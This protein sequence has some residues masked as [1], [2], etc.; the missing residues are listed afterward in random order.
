M[1]L[2]NVL[3]NLSFFGF[4]ILFRF[5]LLIYVAC[6][7]LFEL[8]RM[9]LGMNLLEFDLIWIAYSVILNEILDVV[10]LE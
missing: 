3:I 4:G 8:R 2:W 1:K 6:D 9:T 10:V 5:L 7:Q